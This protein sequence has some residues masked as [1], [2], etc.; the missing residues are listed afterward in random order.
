MISTWSLSKNL[1]NR[2]IL[3]SIPGMIMPT[4][5]LMP[6]IDPKYPAELSYTFM[7][8]IC[9]MSLAMTVFPLLM[10]CICKA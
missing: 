1:F 2:P 5:V 10:L 9:A 3:C 6:S 8:K 4:D 7:T